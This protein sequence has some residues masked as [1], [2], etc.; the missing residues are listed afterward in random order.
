MTHFKTFCKNF[1]KEINGQYQEYDENQAV[2][3]VP[4]E[5]GRFQAITGH[6]TVHSM[7][8]MDMVTIK[9]KISEVN[10]DIPYE[11]LLRANSEYPYARFVIEGEH[12][13]VEAGAFLEHLSEDQIK[14]MMLE[15]AKL[16]DDWEKEITGKDIH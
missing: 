6:L 8:E 14:E 5:E 3:I 10:G 15:V 13:K 7:T 1:A 4:L 11:D 12:L 2:V 16:A 9:S